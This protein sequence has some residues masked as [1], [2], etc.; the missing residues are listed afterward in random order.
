MHIIAL[1]DNKRRI[2][3]IK[4]AILSIG[5]V[6]DFTSSET[7][8]F[9]LLQYENFD[10]LV[11]DIVDGTENNA[12]IIKKICLTYRSPP[13]MAL[14]CNKRYEIGIEALDHGAD[15]Y[16]F[17]PIRVEE[18]QA[19]IRAL[20]RRRNN[21]RSPVIKLGPLQMNTNSRTCQLEEEYLDLTSREKGIL[22]ILVMKPNEIISKDQ[23]MSHMYSI[24]DVI[25]PAII[26]TY[27][28]KIRKKIRHNLLEIK[29][30]YGQG[31]MLRVKNGTYQE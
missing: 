23:I 25:T 20:L 22:E 6:V 18:F 21:Q 17:W 9:S 11:L 26:E 5:H 3:I 4:S 31:Y 29:T 13:I 10:I 1:A 28:S 19:R 27:V 30:V 8:M 2:S 16:L 12:A 7:E 15:D 14:I 24:N